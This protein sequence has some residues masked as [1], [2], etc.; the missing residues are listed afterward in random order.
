M[1]TIRLWATTTPEVYK[2]LLV[3]LASTVNQRN[4]TRV[5]IGNFVEEAVI[6][7]LE[8]E[9]KKLNKLTEKNL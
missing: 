2:N 1:K 8:R 6:E 9:N 4:G 5:K 3:Y 7:K